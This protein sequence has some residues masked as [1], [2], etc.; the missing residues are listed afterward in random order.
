MY[1]DEYNLQREQKAIARRRTLRAKRE[2]DDIKWF[3]STSAGRRIMWGLLEEAGVYKASFSPDTHLMAFQEG[4]KDH[5]IKLMAKLNTYCAGEY[6]LMV[7]EHQESELDLTM[8]D[9]I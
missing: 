8:K 4:K 3:M 5:G 9:Y 2:K 1:E 7:R 6:N